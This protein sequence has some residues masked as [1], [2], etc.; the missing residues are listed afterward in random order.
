[1][2]KN[3][4]IWATAIALS[5]ASGAIAIG[6]I[7][8]N[9]T[10]DLAMSFSP[11]NGFAAES[12]AENLTLASIA[13]NKGEFPD[14]MDPSSMAMA[15]AIQAF[16]S[17]P[18][19]PGAIAVIALARG[20]DD[21]HSLMGKAF[22]LSRRQGFVTAWMIKDSSSREDITALLQYYDTLLRTSSSARPIALPIMASALTN[23]SSIEPIAV[24]LSRKPPWD[25]DFWRTAGNINEIATGLATLRSRIHSMGLSNTGKN[26]AK[27]LGNLVEGGLYQEAFQLYDDLTNNSRKSSKDLVRGGDFESQPR[28]FPIEW[29]LYSSGQFGAEVDSKNGRLWVGSMPKVRA[30]FATQI[31]HLPAGSYTLRVS[32]KAQTSDPSDPSNPL[33]LR[34]RCATN[35]HG[36][37]DEILRLND[38]I[39]SMRIR[40]A[41]QDCSYYWLTLL[42]DAQD[43]TERYDFVVS[44]ISLTKS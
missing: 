13:E 23:E 28:L 31:I 36:R 20:E 3:I 18:V 39:V 30:T 9:K 21:R 16:K 24:M 43:S 38:G 44:S 37:L 1:M 10:P 2:L 29:R 41:Q 22:N 15:M 6:A 11:T 27:I 4:L 34:L 8:K 17:E 25:R 33:F 5:L 14:R 12:K 40:V 35:P 19:T 26:D 32:S 7:A 42:G